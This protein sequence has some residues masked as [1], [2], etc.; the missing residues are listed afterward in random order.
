MRLN[1]RIKPCQVF[2]HLSLSF[3]LWTITR[4]TATYSIFLFTHTPFI[5]WS[6]EQREKYE[7]E[8]KNRN[9]K[10]TINFQMLF[11]CTQVATSLT[12]VQYF[13]QARLCV[14][15][16]NDDDG[17]IKGNW[18]LICSSN[19]EFRF[20]SFRFCSFFLFTLNFIERFTKRHTHKNHADFIIKSIL[21]NKIGLN[22]TTAIK[23]WL[24]IVD[25]NDPIFKKYE[26]YMKWS[27]HMLKDTHTHTQEKTLN[28]F[29]VQC[30]FHI[31]MKFYRFQPTHTVHMCM[32]Y[33][34]QNTY[35]YYYSSVVR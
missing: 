11:M 32:S 9:E 17:M 3:F 15:V 7:H 29:I 33:S 5:Q 23:I 16:Y 4:T 31:T 1:I 28:K 27:F 12:I 30:E 19:F 13:V 8:Q 25:L 35:S 10:H 34:D 22:C 18:F 21:F 24:T 2:P 14:C 26:Y 6:I 20:V